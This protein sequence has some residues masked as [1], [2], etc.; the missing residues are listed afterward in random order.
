[1]YAYLT[2]VRYPKWLAWGGFLSMACF[3]LPLLFNNRATFYKLLGS[4]KNGTFDKTPDLQQWG[5]LL[6]TDSIIEQGKEVHFDYNKIYGRQIYSW[7]KRFNCSIWTVLLEPIEGQG[8]WDGKEVFG[9]MKKNSL[10][11]GTIAVLTRATIKINRLKNFWSHVDGVA[12]NMK[13]S[14]GFMMSLG[15]GEV[16]W[17]KQATF[18]V[19]ENKESMKNFSYKMKEHAE[20][21]KKTRAEKWYKEELFVRFKI[22]ATHGSINNINPLEG[23][24]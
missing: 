13:S 8:T 1:M 4:G 5:I 24:I 16:P 6:V 12:A 14:K 11:H 2:I 22:L 21:I 9:K 10:H 15:L 20:V 18:S 3:R 17:I 19:W 23:N 7:W